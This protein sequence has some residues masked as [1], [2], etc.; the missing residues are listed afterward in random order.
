MT[1]LWKHL[2]SSQS[3]HGAQTARILGKLGGRNRQFLLYP[4]KLVNIFYL[5]KY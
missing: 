4:S 5:N 2:K 1:A 3:I